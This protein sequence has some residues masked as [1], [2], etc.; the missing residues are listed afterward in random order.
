LK[1]LEWINS[2]RSKVGKRETGLLVGETQ[3][4]NTEDTDVKEDEHCHS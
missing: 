3:M 2:K 4:M 1:S